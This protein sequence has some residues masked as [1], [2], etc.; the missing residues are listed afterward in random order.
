[1]GTARGAALLGLP[2]YGLAPGCEGS[3][4]LIDGE[5]RAQV[6]VDRPP[7]ALVVKAGR[8]VAGAG[9]YTGPGAP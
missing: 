1:M 3:L 5:N 9:R 4:V 8:V 2:G 7:R 6:L